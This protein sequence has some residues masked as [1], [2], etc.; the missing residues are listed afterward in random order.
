MINVDRIIATV[1]LSKQRSIDM[2]LP[3]FMPI[4]EL[5]TKVLET[6]CVLYPDK[7]DNADEIRLLFMGHRMRND[8]TLASNGVWDGAYLEV[9]RGK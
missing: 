2:E 8:T 9:E 5:S 3:A 7:W 6:I 1:V 4:S